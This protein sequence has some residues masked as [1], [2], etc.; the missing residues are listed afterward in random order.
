MNHPLAGLRSI[1]L[2]LADVDHLL[3]LLNRL[4]AAGKSVIVIEHH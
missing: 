4:M 1:R 2:H 3:E